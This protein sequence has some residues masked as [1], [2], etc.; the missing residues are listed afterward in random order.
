MRR[1]ACTCQRGRQQS[2]VDAYVLLSFAP[3][4]HTANFDPAVLPLAPETIVPALA[5]RFRC[6]CCGSREIEAGPNHSRWC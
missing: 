4:A 2:V 6:T 3:G 1:Y 5:G